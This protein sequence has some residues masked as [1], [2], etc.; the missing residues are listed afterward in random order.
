MI[1]RKKKEKRRI[2]LRYLLKLGQWVVLVSLMIVA[3]FT[4][5]SVLEIPGSYKVYVVQSGSMEPSIAAGSVV[6]TKPAVGYTE[7]DVITF[8]SSDDRKTTITHRIVDVRDESGVDVFV[9]KGDAN[10]SPD[11][12][13][14][15][16]ED[17]LGKLVFSIPFLG[18][19]VN[20]AKTQQGFILLIVVP[21]TLIIYSEA[22]TITKEAKKL[23]KGRK[24]PKL[25]KR[26]NKFRKSLI[27]K[28]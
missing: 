19:P 1:D 5:L 6:V 10:D 14:V 8:S 28:K 4:A 3:G 22:V 7:G 2:N 26:F 23:A 17:I 16:R 25:L 18:Y 11:A 24:T 15:Y 12:G 20:Y 27:K 9:T 13:L 21:A